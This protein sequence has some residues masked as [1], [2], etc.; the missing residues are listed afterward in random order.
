MTLISFRNIINTQI[1][2]YLA[3]ILSGCYES[4]IEVL[5][6]GEKISIV[7]ELQCTSG[8]EG[9]SQ[10]LKIIEH[11]SGFFF[12]EYHYEIGDSN[13]VKFKKYGEDLHIAQSHKNGKYQYTFVDLSKESS[14]IFLVPKL[15]EHPDY[16]DALIS[17]HNIKCDTMGPSRSCRLVGTKTN[18]SNYLEAHDPNYLTPILRCTSNNS[19][20]DTIH[21]SRIVWGRLSAAA[22]KRWRSKA[23]RYLQ[24]PV[25]VK[26]GVRVARTAFGWLTECAE[27]QSF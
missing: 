12:K 21:S 22:K 25:G 16:F 19:W 27:L 18:I 24:R 1:F 17:N 13:D 5:K 15:I 26:K 8:N 7:G 23:L 10:K 9:K 4:E 6:S 20:V 11:V 2:V 14:V 3:I